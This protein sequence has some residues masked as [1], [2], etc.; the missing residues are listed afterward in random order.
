MTSSQPGS[1][2]TPS[3]LP[4]VISA[5]C[6]VLVGMA[7]FLP[8][9]ELPALSAATGVDSVRHGIETGD[10]KYILALAAIGL[11]VLFIARGRRWGSI[12]QLVMAV[13]IA[14]IAFADISDPVSG[15]DVFAE[16]VRDNMKILAGLWI[17]AFAAIIWGVMSVITIVRPV[18]GSASP[19][20]EPVPDA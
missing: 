14:A 2:R 11:V 5:V 17:I 7:V 8:W 1:A 3:R 6:G 12:V 16:F 13:L 15:N 4:V 20:V 19:P 9:V 18:R 10:G